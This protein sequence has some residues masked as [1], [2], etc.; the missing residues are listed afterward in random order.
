MVIFRPY[1][2]TSP[3]LIFKIYIVGSGIPERTIYILNKTWTSSKI[4]PE[5]DHRRSKH[6]APV[7]QFALYCIWCVWQIINL[8]YVITETHWDDKC[9]KKNRN[10]AASHYATFYSLLPFALSSVQTNS[11]AL[12]SHTAP[13]YYAVSDTLS[14]CHSTD[15]TIQQ[16]KQKY[17]VFSS[18]C[19]WTGDKNDNRL[20]NNWQEESCDWTEMQIWFYSLGESNYN[21]TDRYNTPGK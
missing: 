21:I 9:E 5:D 14:T 20:W 7:F 16:V 17:F 2:W 11:C 6:V 13:V 15:V 4:G 18:L 1:F 12:C 8:L 10:Y 19:S 3:S